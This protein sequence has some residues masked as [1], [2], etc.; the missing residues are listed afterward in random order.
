MFT[1]NLELLS[2]VR[3]SSQALAALLSACDEVVAVPP[4]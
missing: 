4:T 1:F 3:T 2:T